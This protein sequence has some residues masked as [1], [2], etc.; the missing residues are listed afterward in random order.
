M[1]T[2]RVLRS[3]VDTIPTKPYQGNS[4]FSPD[5]SCL[6]IGDTAH[7][8]VTLVDTQTGR[9]LTP[10]LPHDAPV[11]EFS[12]SPDGRYLF[13][14]A[15]SGTMR[16]WNVADGSPAYPPLLHHHDLYAGESLSFTADG[17]YALTECKGGTLEWKLDGSPRLAVRILNIRHHRTISSP[18][19]SLMACQDR[20]DWLWDL[21][22]SSKP[23]AHT[24][25]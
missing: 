6:V 15:T 2:G 22:T 8:A 4:L 23:D 5:D 10:P 21:A 19:G 3:F 12:F 18:D 16:V 20:E 14:W 1:N 9:M 17:R 11:T 24:G 25:S 7:K 13:T